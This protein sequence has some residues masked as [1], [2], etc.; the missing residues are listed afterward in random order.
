MGISCDFEAGSMESEIKPTCNK[1][2]IKL[3]GQ[4]ELD[5]TPAKTAITITTASYNNSTEP[6]VT[7][8]DDVKSTD[9]VIP[10][11]PVPPP[12]TETI[13]IVDD[14]E[15]E[16]G[17]II[18]SDNDFEYEAISSDEEFTLRQQI[19]ALEA[20]NRELEK[21]AS[22]SAIGYG[23]RR[24]PNYFKSLSTATATIN[25]STTN[26]TKSNPPLSS[27]TNYKSVSLS[28]VENISSDEAQLIDSDAEIP[29][30]FDN[31]KYG[32][33][34][35]RASKK[36]KRQSR[37]K[38]RMIENEK[39]R[40][41]AH[42]KRRCTDVECYPIEV[43]ITRKKRARHK[44]DDR[45][46][47]R[48]KY[49][50]DSE[51][52]LLRNREELKMALNII[53][54]SNRTVN[55]S[56][57]S[58]KLSVIQSQQTLDKPGT[59]HRKR[60]TSR[61]P[62]RRRRTRSGENSSKRSKNERDRS[63]SRSKIASPIIVHDNNDNDIQDDVIDEAI[64]LEEQE[65]RL[66]ALKSAVLKKHEARKRK[67]LANQIVEQIVRPYSP[68][69]SVVLVADETGDRS[70]DC[71]DSDNNNMDISPISSPGNQYQPM[72]MDLASS[73]E[74]SKSPIFSYDK[75][76]TFPYEPFIDWGT[77]HIP[78]AINPGY[79][80]IDQAA[81]AAAAVAMSQ[82]FAMQP[83]FSMIYDTMQK[84]PM[85]T[86]N[87]MPTLPS[88][89]SDAKENNSTHIDNEDDL[90]A[91]LIEQMR[92]TNTSSSNGS[93]TESTK[94]EIVPKG[95]GHIDSFDSLEEDCLR[96]LLL[97]SKGKKSTVTKDPTN[98][99][100]T[101]VS[102]PEPPSLD[103]SKCDDMPKLAL[104]LREALK[105]LKNNQQNKLTAAASAATASSSSSSSSSAPTTET[106]KPSDKCV[107]VESKQNDSLQD[108][109]QKEIQK[110]V[111]N[112]RLDKNENELFNAEQTATATTVVPLKVAEEKPTVIPHT[113]EK[114]LK[115]TAA[116]ATVVNLKTVNENVVVKPPVRAS[117]VQAVA[118]TQG[119]KA[120]TVAK[121]KPKVV[122]KPKA[123]E[124]PKV[125]EKLKVAEKPKVVERSQSIT[126]PVT[127][128]TT[129]NLSK[130]D[131]I[132]KSTGSPVITTWTAK[133][134]KKLIIS[135][136][137][138]SST[139][140]DDMDCDESATNKRTDADSGS[141][142]N[143][144]N[145]TFQFR[146]DQFLQT[147]RANT[148]AILESKQVVTPATAK[149]AQ[150]TADK[151]T[152]NAASKV[153]ITSKAESS[154]AVAHLP[155]SS[156]LE[157]HRLLNRM[158]LLEKQ[159]EQKSRVKNQATVAAKPLPA[160]PETNF[161]N[162]TVVVQNEN[163]FIQTN[164][165]TE[166]EVDKN[167]TEVIK[168]PLVTKVP[169]N[170]IVGTNTSNTSLAKKVLV[171][172]A[173]AQA[174][175]AVKVAAVKA[176]VATPVQVSSEQPLN[177]VADSNAITESKPA[178]MTLAMF[179][180]KTP[181]IKASLLANY[182]K[183]YKNHGEQYLNGLTKLHRLTCRTNLETQ[184]QQKL[185]QVLDDLRRQTKAI[186]EQL[187][188]QK[189]VTQSLYPVMAATE[190]TITSDR[191]MLLRLENCCNRLGT[192][193]NGPNYKVQCDKDVEIKEKLKQIIIE[194]S[195][196]KQL[197][198]KVPAKDP[199]KIS[200][201]TKKEVTSK[202]IP[203]IPKPIPSNAVEQRME[204]VKTLKKEDKVIKTPINSVDKHPK[205][206]KTELK[207]NES[208]TESSQEKPVQMEVDDAVDPNPS[209]D[210]TERETENKPEQVKL[211]AKPSKVEMPKTPEP[212][213]T[214]VE[215]QENENGV[216]ETKQ[217]QPTNDIA[218]TNEIEQ[219]EKV[220]ELTTLSPDNLTAPMETM[221]MTDN[222]AICGKYDSPL[223]HMQ[224]SAADSKP[225]VSVADRNA[226]V[227]PYDLMGRCE[228][229]QCKYKHLS[230]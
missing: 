186:E 43:T 74:N 161:P 130:M 46:V 52:E 87:S 44:Y 7:I 106:I 24:S 215:N 137:E 84:E 56:T 224:G 219:A 115:V 229:K 160:K 122:A 68:T 8:I 32:R 105:R 61:S 45:K 34:S 42:G 205:V 63:D 166:V 201:L 127:K 189:S 216:N 222:E 192:I 126:P 165:S 193:V 142:S 97:S 71:I 124:K 38:T 66:I 76:Q 212:I 36:E 147:V 167:V 169:S 93:A 221:Q 173:M 54:P 53:E 82:P 99:L 176:A 203:I 12:E 33:A 136:N 190:K 148:D 118:T 55:S 109:D 202:V 141:Q 22:I 149:A 80:D 206:A 4:H 62:E 170:K 88:I 37:R 11:S 154:K 2:F 210:K 51:D 91:Q 230:V 145:N 21:I 116:K 180:K 223:E 26:H 196:L 48:A 131:A 14:A 146:L 25:R 177:S 112:N 199:V 172:N 227:C 15:P 214:E 20:K 6:D 155:M 92:S 143:D 59:K 119:A 200:P 194:K 213:R 83:S 108:C 49:S 178:S 156:Q 139:D 67:Q 157:Y 103:Q 98:D 184:K 198:Q 163:R 50:S 158:K 125:A 175:D 151:S 85:A 174:T 113:V 197:G 57:L 123:V 47:V 150:K 90:R 17:E 181:K 89:Q 95:N 204:S 225:E 188:Q 117:P 187:T 100:Q 191:T 9:D 39:E 140:N 60:K 134:V 1:E 69:D 152:N 110:T 30:L 114:V 153:Q 111:V 94:T 144:S 72:D 195:R 65:L 27:I 5:A 41:L 64:S 104:N 78:V 133:P 29:S 182:I 159:K 208:K 10:L 40:C 28:H 132:R 179:A 79:V 107:Q 18:T 77:V 185:E 13:V 135:L 220:D 211:M 209:K 183:R 23:Y 19:E 128:A 226:I 73:N 129:T 31:N 138:D 207:L 70:N 121:P 75:P 120:T 86:E 16:E 35:H 102:K 168:A 96:S 162:L 101:P 58:H 217:T 3:N 228:D 164:K 171:K 81:A 218:K